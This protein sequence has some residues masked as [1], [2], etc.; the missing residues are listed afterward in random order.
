M[1]PQG[2]YVVCKISPC[3]VQDWG[4]GR[5]NDNHR[6]NVSVLENANTIVSND[7]DCANTHN[8]SDIDINDV[9]KNVSVEKSN[10]NVNKT[11]YASK[12]I[13]N[14]NTEDNKLFFVPTTMFNNGDEAV[15][16]EK[17]LVRKG[18]EM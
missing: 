18:S 12:L 6:G 7:D 2:L 9:S 3:I 15:L 10:D 16:F 5:C 13:D 4:F 1:T 11:S 17:E 14:L 8:S